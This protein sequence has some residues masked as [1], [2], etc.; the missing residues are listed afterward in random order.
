M[1]ALYNHMSITSTSK[2]MEYI[3]FFYQM[4]QFILS[5]GYLSNVTFNQEQSE[6]TPPLR[7]SAMIIKIFRYRG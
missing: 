1:T 3:F 5:M 7:F 4:Q 2:A 6:V